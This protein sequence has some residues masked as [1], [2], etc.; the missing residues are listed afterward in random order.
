MEQAKARNHK[1]TTGRIAQQG[2]KTTQNHA[3]I[4]TR[5]DESWTKKKQI[6][7]IQRRLAD[8]IKRVQA[9]IKAIDKFL[10]REKE[11]DDG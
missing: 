11:K 3:E 5:G 1:T 9:E 4:K 2:I 10:K 7:D 6:E 8:I